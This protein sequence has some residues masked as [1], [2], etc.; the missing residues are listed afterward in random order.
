[1]F[2]WFKKL[3]HLRQPERMFPGVVTVPPETQHE[4]RNAILGIKLEKKR[5]G[6]AMVEGSRALSGMRIH[7]DRIERAL[8]GGADGAQ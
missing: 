5:L 7:M 1:M 8:R 2:G 6:N 4:I 3:L